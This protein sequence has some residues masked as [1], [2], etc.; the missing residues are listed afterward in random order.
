MTLEEAKKALEELKEDYGD[1]EGVSKALYIMYSKDMI[2]LDDFRAFLNILG[3]EFTEEFEAMS[4][5]EKKEYSRD[6][7]A[8]AKDSSPAPQEI[9]DDKP[10]DKAEDGEDDDAAPKAEESETDDKDDDDDDDDDKKAARLFG[11]N[12]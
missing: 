5:D 7:I 3:Y 1:E 4:D 2:S 11:F 10:E 12:K 8:K 9:E 6:E